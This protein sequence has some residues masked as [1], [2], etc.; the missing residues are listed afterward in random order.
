[1][2]KRN[3]RKKKN[4][5]L[6]LQIELIFGLTLGSYLVTKSFTVAMVC[7]GVAAGFVVGGSIWLKERKQHRLF[8]AGMTNIDKFEGKDFEDF[9]SVLFEKH[10]YRTMVTKASGD[11]G[12]D[13][14]LEKDGYRVIVQAKRYKGSVG[15]SAVQEAAAAVNHYKGNEGWVVTNSSFTKQAYSLAKSNNIK[16]IDRTALVRLI[17]Q[18]KKTDT[19]DKIIESEMTCKKCGGPLVLRQGPAG[20]FY[21]CT[22]FPNC[23][24]TSGLPQNL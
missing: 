5:A 10:G 7:A 1:M 15:L 17:L 2:R 4:S 24:Y 14:V 3:K 6:A 8:E 13:L 16:L 22:H 11:F 9:L 12:A 20:A 21:G 23:R 18:V 19:P